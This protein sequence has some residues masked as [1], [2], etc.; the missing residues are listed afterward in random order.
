[1]WQ[2]GKQGFWYRDSK[3][4]KYIKKKHPVITGEKARQLDS[5]E[6]SSNKMPIKES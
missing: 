1:L 4:Q 6:F 3:S 5:Y 2:D